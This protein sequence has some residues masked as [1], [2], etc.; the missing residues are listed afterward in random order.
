MDYITSGPK[1]TTLTIT[2]A[3]GCANTGNISYTPL[4]VM[5]IRLQSFYASWQQEAAQLQ[6]QVANASAFSHFIVEK[7]MDGM[8]YEPIATIP[9]TMAQAKYMYIDRQASA[10][11]GTHYYRLRL[12]DVDGSYT[13]STIEQLKGKAA[14]V[15]AYPNP[16][17]TAIQV[18]LPST[19]QGPVSLVLYGPSGQALLQ[20][21]YLQQ[22]LPRSLQIG[23]PASWPSG[24]YLLR[25]QS[26][27]DQWRIPL[28]RSGN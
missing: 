22:T 24:V 25:I 5:P 27:N 16:F 10:G 14:E 3:D 26:A 15:L 7:S 11:R 18:M 19:L 17:G 9:F 21:R 12:M 4:C 2:S 6:W 20:E 1:T 13:Y 28:W 23:V 8:R